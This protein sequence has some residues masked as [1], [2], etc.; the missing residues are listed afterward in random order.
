VIYRLEFTP[1]AQK[2]LVT[3]PPHDRTRIDKQLLSL[4]ENPR[5]LGSKKLAGKNLYRIRVGNYRVIYRI[6]DDVLVI[7]VVKIGH[8]KDIYRNL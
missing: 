1:V 6:Q 3:L 4:Q 2:T 8:R 7:L 5:P